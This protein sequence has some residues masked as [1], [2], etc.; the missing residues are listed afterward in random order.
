MGTKIQVE[1]F[2]FSFYDDVRRRW[3]RARYM[4]TRES[5]A[6]QYTQFRIEG[7]PE[8]REVESDPGLRFPTAPAGS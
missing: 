1:L 5:I 3:L 8:V 6:A 4:A 7:D 2:H